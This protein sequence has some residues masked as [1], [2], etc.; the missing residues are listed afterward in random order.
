MSTTNG[1]LGYA[2]TRD[3]YLPS[4]DPY[5]AYETPIIMCHL[6]FE[7]DIEDRLVTAARKLHADVT[8]A[9]YVST[10]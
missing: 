3:A 7:A 8:H 2:P 1:Y 4:A 6:P 5:P 10:K 9:A